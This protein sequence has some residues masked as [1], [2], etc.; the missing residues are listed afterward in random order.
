M[1]M[2]M[3]IAPSAHELLLPLRHCHRRVADDCGALLY[4]G[5]SRN[6]DQG[7][8]G[9]ARQHDEPRPARTL[10]LSKSVCV[11]IRVS[12]TGMAHTVTARPQSRVT[13]RTY[14]AK[15]YLARPLEN[16]LDSDFSW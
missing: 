1:N 3:G 4:V 13:T 16:I 8:A 14:K 10:F 5:N 15:R 7:L 6:T 12:G 11:R 2:R 9:A